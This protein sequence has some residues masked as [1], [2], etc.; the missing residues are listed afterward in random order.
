M[1][2]LLPGGAVAAAPQGLAIERDQ[3]G[4]VGPQR[5]GPGGE[6]RLEQG[7]VD[8]IEHHPQPVFLRD[9]EIVLRVPAQE[10][11]VLLTP[12]R[13][14]VIVVAARNRRAGRQEQHLPQRIPDLAGLP[15]V[16]N[17]PE[18]VQQKAQTVLDQYLFHGSRPLW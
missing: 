3:I 7:R 6:A 15:R 11:Q 8:P 16:A 14:R 5:G 12:I 18:M 9:P 17:P 10:L 1:Q 13:D 4:R 2:R